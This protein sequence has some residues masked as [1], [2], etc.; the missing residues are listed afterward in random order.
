MEIKEFITKL[1]NDSDIDLQILEL[2][3]DPMT[4]SIGY[5]RYFWKTSGANGDC[6]DSP[7]AALL[8]YL[9][10]TADDDS[11]DDGMYSDLIYW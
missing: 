5:Q 7:L 9:Q 3:Y 1:N 2:F 11:N 10:K 4:Q 8:D 6:F